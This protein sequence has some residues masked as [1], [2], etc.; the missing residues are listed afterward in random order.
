MSEI[1]FPEMSSTE[2]ATGLVTTWFAENGEAVE[3]GDLLAEVAMDKVD[4]EI[5]AQ[6]SGTL[7]ILVG[8]EVEVAQ[9]TPIGRID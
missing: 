6:S 1:V 8:E 2:G 7:T 4:M 9:G 3:A 5:R